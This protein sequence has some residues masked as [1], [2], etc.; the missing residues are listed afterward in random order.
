MAWRLK[1]VDVTFTETHYGD[2]DPPEEIQYDLSADGRWRVV[3][4][5]YDSA[6][7]DVTLYEKVFVFHAADT[8][9]AEALAAAKAEGRK[10]RGTRAVV[11]EL[12]QS[13]GSTYPID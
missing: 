11:A 9:A 3:V 5:Y 10:V 6:Q 4:S 1:V 13:I 7:P 2:G 12:E 8:S